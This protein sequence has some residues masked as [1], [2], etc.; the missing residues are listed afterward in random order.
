ML[1]TDGKIRDCVDLRRI[2]ELGIINIFLEFSYPID[3]AKP[4]DP[5][6]RAWRGTSFWRSSFKVWIS[7]YLDGNCNGTSDLRDASMYAV[8]LD[9]ES[10]QLLT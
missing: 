7:L 10:R 3:S 2:Q 9:E 6:D 1:R 8:L 4:D 5:A